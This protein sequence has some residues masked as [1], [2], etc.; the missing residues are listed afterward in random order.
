[1]PTDRQTQDYL[2]CEG[3]EDILNKGGE[4]WIADKLAT[5][6]RS[7]PLYE[8]LTKQPPLF[9]EEGMAV[10]LAG[11]NLEIKIDKLIH[12]AL[13][14]FWK[15]SVH[16]WSGTKTEPRIEL[17]PYSEVI[18]A[19]LRDES[20]FPNYVYP[21]A[22]VSRPL[23]AQITLLDPYEGVHQGWRT[24]FMHVPGLLFMLAVGKTVD[25]CVR[26]LSIHNPG[27]PINIS[28]ELIADIEQL[29]ARTLRRARKT[30][31]Y[32]RS[33]AKYDKESEKPSS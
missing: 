27:N 24:F 21:I 23:R 16:S 19:W 33:K 15:A 31:A 11:G 20:G 29:M 25:E 6:E 5:W 30:Q 10:Y 2:L 14:M 18:R 4:S 13:G 17:G 3:C 26:A 1:M 12:F 22:I 9:D 7:F 32:L 8:V 28:D